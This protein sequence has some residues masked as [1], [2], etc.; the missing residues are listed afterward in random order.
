MDPKETESILQMEWAAISAA[1]FLFITALAVI[2]MVVWLLTRGFYKQQ[3]VTLTA[4]RELARDQSGA[5]EKAQQDLQQKF[6]ASEEAR[7]D[8]ETKVKEY[9]KAVEL[10]A[11][12]RKQAV[13][14]EVAEAASAT[15]GA[16]EGL[17]KKED[18]VRNAFIE[19]EEILTKWQTSAT[20]PIDVITFRDLKGFQD[21]AK[22]IEDEAKGKD[23]D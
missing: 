20:K 8:L 21:A 14:S 13:S 12:Q 5:A 11:A 15:E 2:G 10:Q 1:P 23:K 6:E 9:E 19:F 22:R 7:K 4:H 18:D 17:K 16:M 3:I